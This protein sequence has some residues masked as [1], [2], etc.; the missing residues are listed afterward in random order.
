MSGQ[1]L[2]FDLPFKVDGGGFPDFP[3]I[4]ARGLFCGA[5]I[6]DLN[7][8]KLEF[9]SISFGIDMNSLI[10]M[11]VYDGSLVNFGVFTVGL[12]S[13]G[14]Q[15]ERY[16]IFNLM[17][18]SELGGNYLFLS[19]DSQRAIFVGSLEFVDRCMSLVEDPFAEAGRVFESSFFDE[20][21][22]SEGIGFLRTYNSLRRDTGAGL[23]G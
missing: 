12:G 8:K 19:D 3:E 11:Y 14:M 21:E 9:I 17:F 15:A 22:I 1:T 4:S 18:E 6:S 2:G 23:V 16:S 10:R 5:I 7:K 20:S 13:I